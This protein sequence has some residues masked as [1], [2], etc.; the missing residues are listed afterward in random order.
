[1]KNANT[2]SIILS[3]SCDKG[4]KI[5]SFLKAVPHL[6]N[7]SATGINNISIRLGITPEHL[8]ILIDYVSL[9]GGLYGN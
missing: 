6:K 4:T 1:M 8:T 7:W 5:I 9:G 3:S 2:S